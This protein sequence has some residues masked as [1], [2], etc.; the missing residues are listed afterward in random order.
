MDIVCEGKW[1]TTGHLGML[2]VISFVLPKPSFKIFESAS[3]AQEHFVL[4][5]L[6]SRPSKDSELA[7]DRSLP[8]ARIPVVIPAGKVPRQSPLG[9]M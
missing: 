7:G 3:P 6:H 4:P 1:K 8:P 2:S 5:A 9:L